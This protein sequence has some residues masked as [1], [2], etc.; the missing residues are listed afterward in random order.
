MCPEA[1]F[2]VPDWGELVESGIGLSYR[3]ANLCMPGGPVQQPYARVDYIPQSATKN[4][5]TDVD[6]E[7]RIRVAVPGP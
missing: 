1:K 4:L 5:A 6:T 3:L 7:K 2:S